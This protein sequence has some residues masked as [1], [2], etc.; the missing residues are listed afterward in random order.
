MPE[1][2]YSVT[3]KEASTK[4]DATT[5]KELDNILLNLMQLFKLRHIPKYKIHCYELDKPTKK[6]P[7][8][9]FHIH[10]LVVSNYWSFSRKLPYKTVNIYAGFGVYVKLLIKPMDRMIWAGYCSKDK[11]DKCDIIL[12]KIQTFKTDFDKKLTIKVP[13][14]LK[15]FQE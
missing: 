11:I 5:K 1:Q 6:Y 3:I 15:F 13:C 10:C 9:R 7:N 4:R 14:I 8:G 2:F 12:K